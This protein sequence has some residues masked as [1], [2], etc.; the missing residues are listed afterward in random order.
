MTRIGGEELLRS[1][2]ESVATSALPVIVL[3]GSSEKD[4]ELA[5][6]EAGA[7]DY[8]R[9]PLDPPRLLARVKA[10]LRRAAT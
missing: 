6:M 10:V 9:K 7:D 4:S 3:T 1:V 5:V 2:R 8:L